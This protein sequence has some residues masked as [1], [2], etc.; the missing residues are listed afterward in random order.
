MDFNFK[1]T[2]PI[3]LQVAHQLEEGILQEIFKERGQAPSTNE[4]SKTYKINPTTVLKGVNL[5]VEAGVLEKQRGIGMFVCE[6]AKSHLLKKRKKEF[7]EV[8]MAR[9]LTEAK[10]LGIAKD[11]LIELI[12]RRE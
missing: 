9:F 5:L 7:F 2:T 12:Q 1:S 8:E 10:K 3:Y 6:G 4:I 11:E